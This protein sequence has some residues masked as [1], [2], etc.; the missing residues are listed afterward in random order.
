MN[1][2]IAAVQRPAFHPALKKVIAGALAL[3]AFFVVFHYMRQPNGVVG[4][5]SKATRHALALAAEQL[6]RADKTGDR[7]AATQLLDVALPLTQKINDGAV[8]RPA[9]RGCQLAGAH[10]A[11]GVLAVMNGGSWSARGRFEEALKGC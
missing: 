4:V 7:A 11:D 2:S 10:L 9:M 6:Q 3:A 5:E 8:G 1:D